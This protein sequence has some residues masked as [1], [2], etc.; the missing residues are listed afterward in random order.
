MKTSDFDYDLPQERIATHPARPRDAA[1]MLHVGAGL[2]DLKISDLPDL[3][4]AKD[5]LVV[6]DTKVIPVRLTGRRNKAKIETTLHYQVTQNRWRAFARPAKKLKTD[7]RI[8]F[9]TNFSAQVVEKGAAGEILL[10]FDCAGPELLEAL[11]RYGA[12]PLPPYIKRPDGPEAGDRADYQTIFATRQG[13]V[14]A[15][16]AGLHF[17]PTLLAAIAAR[18]IETVAITLHVGAGTYLPVKT[19][20]LED[21]KMHAEYGEITPPAAAAINGARARGGRIVAVGTTALRLLETASDDNREIMAFTGQT[22]IFIL[23]GYRFKG[24]DAL[25][26]NF[27]LP[28]STLLMLVSAFAGQDRIKAAYDHAIGHGY[29]FYSYGDCCFLEPAR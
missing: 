2:E 26:T 11:E 19:E 17:T 24:V 16:T 28:R 13:A 18:G 14:A 6:N 3:L 15:P 29:R 4:D 20:A 22:D 25:V 7:D 27:H 9:A 10:Q 12:M 8:D 5:V 23:P 1:R 21:H